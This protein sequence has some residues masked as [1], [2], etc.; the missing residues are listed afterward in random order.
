MKCNY[1]KAIQS[2]FSHFGRLVCMNSYQHFLM[3]YQHMLVLDFLQLL[4]TVP[5]ELAI[6]RSV[7]NPILHVADIAKRSSILKM[8]DLASC[9]YTNDSKTA[10]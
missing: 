6:V 5:F 1:I 10:F 3:A 2:Y 4:S 7:P 9:M 8:Y